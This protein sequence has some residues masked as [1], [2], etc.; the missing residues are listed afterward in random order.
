[1]SYD[2]LGAALCPVPAPVALA[3]EVPAHAAAMSDDALTNS[4]YYLL[5]RLPPLARVVQ[6]RDVVVQ[7]LLPLE[8]V[9]GGAALHHEPALGVDIYRYYN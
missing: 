3:P 4:K 6:G 2:H 1:M 8:D 7:D 9:G 5:E